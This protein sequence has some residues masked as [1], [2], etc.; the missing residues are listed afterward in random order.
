VDRASAESMLKSFAIIEAH[1][2]TAKGVLETSTDWAEKSGLKRDVVFFK[3]RLATLQADYDRAREAAA[4]TYLDGE[5]REVRIS[6]W[7]MLRVLDDVSAALDYKSGDFW[8]ER[9][10]PRD[11][12]KIKPVY[13]EVLASAYAK[14]G[15]S[16]LTIAGIAAA[17]AA[18]LTGA[19]VIAHAA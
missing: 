4:L 1:M 6:D 14:P 9:G 16:V 19:I 7:E 15:P 2:R 5:P 3:D 18:L 17:A 12:S 10:Q 13:P 8:V 11:S